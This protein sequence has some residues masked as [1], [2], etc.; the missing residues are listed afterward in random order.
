MT[1]ESSKLTFEERLK[2]KSRSG[3]DTLNSKVEV[4][5]RKEQAD[6]LRSK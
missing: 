2:L 4:L 3:F 6:K 1:E 5:A